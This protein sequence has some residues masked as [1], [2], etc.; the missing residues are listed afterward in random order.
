L[1]ITV[2]IDSP[3]SILDKVS[4]FSSSSAKLITSLPPPP[5]CGGGN[6][7]Y[8]NQLIKYTP[9][10]VSKPILK[11]IYNIEVYKVELLRGAIPNWLLTDRMAEDVTMIL[12]F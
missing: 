6:G 1:T 2:A 8:Y 11:I 10:E 7:S 5:P 3:Q 4:L 9:N 12:I